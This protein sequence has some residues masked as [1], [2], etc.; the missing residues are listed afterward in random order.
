VRHPLI[1]QSIVAVVTC[2]IASC[3]G[4]SGDTTV[5]GKVTFKGVPADGAVV[6][7]HPRGAA[8]DAAARIAVSTGSDGSFGLGAAGQREIPAGDYDVTVVWE[9]PV[10]PAARKDPGDDRQDALAG[11]YA[12]PGRSGLSATIRLGENDLTPFELK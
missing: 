9:R 7:F 4:R 8:V 6:V 5:H 11:R 10:P 2:L 12:S 1:R 3:S